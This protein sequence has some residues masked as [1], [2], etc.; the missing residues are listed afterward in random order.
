M[1]TLN[2][3]QE[4]NRATSVKRQGKADRQVYLKKLINAV[5]ELEDD[6][7]EAL[8]K[9]SQ[10]WINLNSRKVLSARENNEP[11][12]TV[13]IEDFPPQITNG[14]DQDPPEAPAKVVAKKPVK[15]KAKAPVKAAAKKVAK[16][17]KAASEPKKAET[18]AP[19]KAPAK[20]ANVRVPSG[21]DNLRSR[22]KYMVLKKPDI[23]L[24]ALID[25]L[26]KALG[27]RPSKITVSATRSELRHSMSILRDLGMLKAGV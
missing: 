10:D 15:A 22:I 12:G 21:K 25:Q 6:N 27:I 18:K 2:I 3:E 8:S 13:I 24:D 4:L 23:S 1:S 7:W 5:Q 16:P 26:E 20:A 17:V 11:E 14:K 9:S 19:A